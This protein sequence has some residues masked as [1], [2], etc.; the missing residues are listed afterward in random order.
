MEVYLYH[1]AS[2]FETIKKIRKGPE[3][4]ISLHQPSS[5]G[6]WLSFQNLSIFQS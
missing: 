5:S 1:H 6:F 2:A 3:I 4:M